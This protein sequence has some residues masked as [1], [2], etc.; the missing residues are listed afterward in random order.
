ML[1]PF[2]ASAISLKKLRYIVPNI[3]VSCPEFSNIKEKFVNAK[4]EGVSVLCPVKHICPP[5]LKKFP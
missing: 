5:S 3:L 4:E 1:I 2:V